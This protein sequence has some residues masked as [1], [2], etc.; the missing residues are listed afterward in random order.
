MDIRRISLGTPVV[1]QEL[2]TLP[3]D[4]TPEQAKAAL[5][6]IYNRQTDLVHVIPPFDGAIESDETNSFK[7]SE[8]W[9]KGDPR[10]GPENYTVRY[11]WISTR[12]EI[13]FRLS[14]WCDRF[15]LTLPYTAMGIK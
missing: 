13:P 4:I 11:S 15:C 6:E 2:P 12:K 10:F 14:I 8:C 3:S 5:T 1:D 7:F 9:D